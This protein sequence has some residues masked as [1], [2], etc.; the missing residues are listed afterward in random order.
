MGTNEQAAT[1]QTLHI[2]VG[3]GLQSELL[4]ALH[5]DAVMHDVAQR[6][7]R[8]TLSQSLFGSRDGTHHTETKT[9]IIV[10]DDFHCKMQNSRFK[11][12]D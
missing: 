6:V 10:D 1:T 12:Q 3:Y 2:G 4:E 11:I 9:R 5:L 8:T 7:D